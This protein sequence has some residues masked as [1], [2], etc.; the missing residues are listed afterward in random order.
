MDLFEN[1]GGGK[2]QRASNQTDSRWL[3][4]HG[5]L[6]WNRRNVVHAIH[7]NDPSIKALQDQINKLKKGNP[8]QHA[9]HVETEQPFSI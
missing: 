7:E 1:G 9:E 5:I 4:L 2:L 6:N 3:N 8:S